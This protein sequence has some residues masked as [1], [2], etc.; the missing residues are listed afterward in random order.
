MEKLKKPAAAANIL[1]VILEMIGTAISFRNGIEVLRWY[2]VLSNIFALI[3]S[4]C[5]LGAA[6]LRNEIPAWAKLMR[7]CAAVCLSVTF[8]VV[9]FV[10]VPM[11]VPYGMV[12][13]VLYKG[14][15]IY[16][17]ILCPMIS[18]VSLVF[19]EKNSGIKPFHALIAAVPTFL[20]GTVTMLLNILRVMEGPYPFL[21][22][23]Q[24]PWY[25]SVMWYVL[26]IGL[27]YGI[28]ALTGMLIRKRNRT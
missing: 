16:H 12:G 9:V 1:I 2:T 20:Y 3:A 11:A 13:D 18:F 22:V 17:H 4:L 26:I 27:A 6:L 19:L 7:Y 21:L 14:P 24:Q 23:Y 15:Q 10:L 8:L 5:W 25:A 28:A